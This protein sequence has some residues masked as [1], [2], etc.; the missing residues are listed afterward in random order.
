MCSFLLG[1]DGQ[2][3]AD[4]DDIRIGE[5]VGLG[6]LGVERA[7]AVELVGDVPQAVARDDGVGIALGHGGMAADD[8][9]IAFVRRDI[10]SSSLDGDAALRG[11]ILLADHAAEIIDDVVDEDLVVNHHAVLEEL[12][13][14]GAEHGVAVAGILE[15]V[16][17]GSEGIG[18][19][20]IEGLTADHD[21]GN[22]VRAVD[23]DELGL[24]VLHHGA[25]NV[26]IDGVGQA[27]NLQEA[28]ALAGIG[29]GAELQSVLDLLTG[30]LWIT[31]ASSGIGRE[32][33]RRYA[34]MGCR[35]ILTARRADRLQTLAKELH[36]AHGTECRIETADLSRAEEC[37]RLCEVLAD[38]HIDIFINNAGFGVCGSIL[39]TEE[40][41]EEE[42]I[43][44]NVAAMARLFRAVVRK[45]HAQGGGT[46]LNV[47][48]SAGLLPGGPYMAGYYASK[49]Y[50]VSMTRGVAEEL[51]E[52]HS[53]VYVCALCPGPV[54]TEFNDH[55]GVVFALRGITPELCVEEALL[56]MMHRK[57]IIVP[58]AFMRLCTS[59]QRLVPIPLLM[60]I[61]ARQQ[62][63]KL[64]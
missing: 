16:V 2:D 57:T 54:D 23:L 35:L 47:A 37:S 5:L 40:A 45:M 53:P 30:D 41:R 14:L 64:G 17:M 9:L 42:M 43:Q 62:K 1:G 19:V 49:A 28:A 21:V 56:G 33:A 31:G 26:R 32:F 61:V 48:S 58:S 59:A 6:Q 29:R 63:K 4:V 15:H 13:V 7:G 39:E 51:R 34:A 18:L 22:T 27:G 20:D 38:E 55:A 52:M 36:T 11:G 44:V 50:V 24:I 3:L 25:G 8:D 10:G 12:D 46:I 60:P